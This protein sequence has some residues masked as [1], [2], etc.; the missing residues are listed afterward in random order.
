MVF[1]LNHIAKSVREPILEQEKIILG[2][3]NQMTA[4]NLTK[5]V[6]TEFDCKTI[7][8]FGHSILALFKLVWLRRRILYRRRL[9]LANAVYSS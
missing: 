2:E 9:T 5:S 3:L 1:E 8:L 7:G 6:K 4:T